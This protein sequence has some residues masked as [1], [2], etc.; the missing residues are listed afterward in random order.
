MLAL[1]AAPGMIE[2]GVLRPCWLLPRREW[3]TPVASAFL[4]ADL[5]PL[6]F[7]GFTFLAFGFSLERTM[8]SAPFAA[9]YAVGL[10]ASALGTWVKHRRE[11]G[12]RTLGASKDKVGIRTSNL[13]GITMATPT[14]TAAA[15]RQVASGFAL[16]V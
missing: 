14:G 11:P 9:L 4:H 3:A 15:A 12:Y 5:G 1:Y 16:R 7:N 6:L 8:G 13:S 10:I 2:R